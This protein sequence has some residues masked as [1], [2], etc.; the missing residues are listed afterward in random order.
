MVCPMRIAIAALALTLPASAF[1]Q[2]RNRKL[3]RSTRVRLLPNAWIDGME[4]PLK[5]FM[6]FDAAAPSK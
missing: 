5:V 3:R 1:A 6:D 2:S 4:K